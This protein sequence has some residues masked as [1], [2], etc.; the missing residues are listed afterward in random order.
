[1]LQ[2]ARTHGQPSQCSQVHRYSSGTTLVTGTSMEPS[3]VQAS[4][5][6]ELCI[7]DD[8]QPAMNTGSQTVIST[9]GVDTHSGTQFPEQTCLR[10]QRLTCNQHPSGRSPKCTPQCYKARRL[11]GNSHN[12]RNFHRCNSR[13]THATGTSMGPSPAQASGREGSS[14]SRW[15]PTSLHS[16]PLPLARSG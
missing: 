12:A 5:R 10:K 4:R 13:S 1:M 15:L 11:M 7:V 8:G 9:D 6:E 3:P 2:G 14:H 16:S